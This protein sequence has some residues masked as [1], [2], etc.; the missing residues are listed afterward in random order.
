LVVFGPGYICVFG[1]ILRVNCRLPNGIRRAVWGVSALVQGAWLVVGV[2]VTLVEGVRG[3]VFDVGVNSWW[4]FAFASSAYA[5]FFD[6][7]TVPP[8][9]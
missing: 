9:N 1:Y 8:Q 2:Y 5:L 7:E 6:Q 3:F 4:A